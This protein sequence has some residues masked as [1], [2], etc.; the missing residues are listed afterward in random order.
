M[1]NPNIQPSIQDELDNRHFEKLMKALANPGC[2]ITCDNLSWAT[3]C[4]TLLDRETRFFFDEPTLRQK[5]QATGALPS[6]LPQAQYV[7]MSLENESDVEAIKHIAI[8]D[9]LYPEKGALLIAPAQFGVGTALKL[10]GPG[11]KGQKTIHIGGVH[12]EFWAMRNALISYPLGF[13]IFFFGQNSL[14]GLPRSTYVEV[15]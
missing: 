1:Q 11:I 13:D 4:E 10:S 7:F 3:F 2:D 6:S 14:I 15:L 5:L 12:P 8:G 9:L